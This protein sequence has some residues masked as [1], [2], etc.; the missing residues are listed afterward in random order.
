MRYK[1]SDITTFSINLDPQQFFL[2]QKLFMQFKAFRRMATLLAL[3]ITV[4]TSYVLLYVEIAHIILY[5]RMSARI[6]HARPLEKAAW[7]GEF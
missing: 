1:R 5:V 7:R 2:I 6:L 4:H 3:H